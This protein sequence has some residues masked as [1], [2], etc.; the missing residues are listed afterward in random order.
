[1]KS[2]SG[3][4][5]NETANSVEAC[6]VHAPAGAG[7]WRALRPNR[8][9]QGGCRR[10]VEPQRSGKRGC[11][12]SGGRSL[13]QN[14]NSAFR[15]GFVARRAIVVQDDSSFGHA[16]TFSSFVAGWLRMGVFDDPSAAETWLREA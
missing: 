7:G 11:S 12:G 3:R 15:P 6:A 14:S 10:A 16:R 5:T 2:G 13:R 9:P 8:S 1:M 4:A